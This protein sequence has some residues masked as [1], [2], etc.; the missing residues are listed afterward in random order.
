MVLFC[1]DQ[2]PYFEYGDCVA[3][4]N[5]K[6]GIIECLKKDVGV[7]D[8]DSG[9]S[10]LPDWISTKAVLTTWLADALAFELWIGCESSYVHSIYYSDLPW[11]MGR[12]LSQQKARSVKLKLGITDDNA[13]EKMKEVGFSSRL[14]CSDFIFV[15]G[16]FKF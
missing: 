15:H 5:E 3:Y 14:M 16:G 1:L 6:E 12:I 10:S 8:L 7:V 9:V 4:N 11:P 13:R 2:I